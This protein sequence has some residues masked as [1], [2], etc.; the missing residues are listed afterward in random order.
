[1]GEENKR[2]IDLIKSGEAAV[3]LQESS[4]DDSRQITAIGLKAE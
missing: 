2:V 3:L 4:T 1:M